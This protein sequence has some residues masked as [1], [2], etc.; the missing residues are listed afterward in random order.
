MNKIFMNFLKVKVKK[1]FF[2]KN[3]LK[4]KI[5]KSIFHN[6]NVNP[7]KKQY[8]LYSAQRIPN[9]HLKIK[10]SCLLSG[11]NSSVSKNFFISRHMMKKNLNLNKLQNVKINSW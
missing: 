2:F 10:N 9:K 11:R 7:L 5:L 6:Q 1:K 3:E 8:A 4:K